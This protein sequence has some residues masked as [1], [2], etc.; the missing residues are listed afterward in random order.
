MRVILYEIEFLEP[1]CRDLRK[2]LSLTRNRIGQNAIE[3]RD[4]IRGDEEQTISEIVD[5]SHLAAA[6]FLEAG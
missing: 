2:H 1:K 6:Q 3:S 5:I 4:A